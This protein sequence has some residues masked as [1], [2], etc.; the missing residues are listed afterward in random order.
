MKNIFRNIFILTVGLFV[1][2]ACDTGRDSRFANDPSTGWIEFNSSATTTGQT[3]DLVSV[4]LAINVPVYRN[5]LTV[6]YSLE[7]G[8]GDFTQYVT[9]T[10]GSVFIDPEQDFRLA[11]VEIPLVNMEA[12]RNFVTTFDIVITSVE[13]GGAVTVGVDENSITRHTVTIPCSN[14]DILPSDFFV[15]DYAIADV[16]A[17]IGPGN[18][19]ENIGAGVVTLSV[20]PGNPN[21]RLFQATVLPAFLGATLFDFSLEFDVDSDVVTLGGFTGSGISCSGPEYGF[22]GA[23]T[24]D[25]GAWDV[26]NDQAIT[27]NYTEDPLVGCGGPYAAQFSLTKL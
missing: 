20:D 1:L 12:G 15:G 26:C 2:Q 4:R 7:A 21:R 5:G 25:S 13:G 24:A 6:S 23:A 14:P 27:I 18:G 10:T 17:T 9:S 3:A 19:T 16:T 11:F 8:E 22:T